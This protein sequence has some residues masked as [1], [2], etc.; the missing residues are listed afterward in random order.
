MKMASQLM[1][2]AADAAV[3]AEDEPLAVTV[4]PL[5]SICKFPTCTE[6]AREE[7]AKNPGFTSLA[8]PMVRISVTGAPAFGAGKPKSAPVGPVSASH[9]GGPPAAG[10]RPGYTASRITFG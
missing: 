10:V 3:S 2:M 1:S 8:E 4:A 6:V 7:R 5:R 9:C